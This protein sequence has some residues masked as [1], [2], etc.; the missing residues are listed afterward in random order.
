MKEGNVNMMSQKRQDYSNYLE[1]LKVIER[2]FAMSISAILLIRCINAY[3]GQQAIVIKQWEP[4][5][6]VFDIAGCHLWEF[7]IQVLQVAFR[8][9]SLLPLHDHQGYQ[10]H[11]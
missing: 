3:Q 4:C 7:Y 8:G 10:M 1:L 9:A 6:E 2:C 5:L 11:L